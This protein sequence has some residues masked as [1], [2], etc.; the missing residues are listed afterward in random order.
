MTI[1]TLFLVSIAVAA[2]A[3]PER[4]AG[5]SATATL[6]AID[7]LK[8]ATDTL[9]ARDTLGIKAGS[10]TGAKT[11]TSGT[12]TTTKRDSIIG[13]DSVTPFDPTKKSLPPAKRP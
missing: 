10:T 2:C 11:Q 9:P 1:R 3:R 7:T 8:P 6:P 5:D 13:R 4:T 12:K